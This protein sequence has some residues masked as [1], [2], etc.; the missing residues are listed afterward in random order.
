MIHPEDHIR[1]AKLI[2]YRWRKRLGKELDFDDLFSTACVG[3][4]K[5][6]RTY[7]AERGTAFSTYAVLLMQN[8]IFME[9]RKQRR[10]RGLVHLDHQVGEWGTLADLIEAKDFGSC[11]RMY[12]HSEVAATLEEVFEVIRTLTG[13]QQQILTLYYFDELTQQQ[14]GR[15]LGVSQAQVSRVIKNS[16]RKL[17]RKLGATAG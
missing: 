4:V 3:L 5:A 16:I 1:L 6:A 9:L 2:A 15:E 17:R 13:Q 11:E 10:H 7:S 14:I 8:E 12:R